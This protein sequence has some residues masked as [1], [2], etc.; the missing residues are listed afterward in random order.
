MCSMSPPIPEMP[1]HR[2]GVC[3]PRLTPLDALPRPRAASPPPTLGSVQAASLEYN[4]DCSVC[5]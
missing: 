3:V 2:A 5:F 4:M 1:Q